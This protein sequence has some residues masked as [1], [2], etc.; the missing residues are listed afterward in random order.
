MVLGGNDA[1]TGNAGYGSDDELQRRDW[2]RSRSTP[3]ERSLG[4][5]K[6]GMLK[7]NDCLHLYHMCVEASCLCS[8]IRCTWPVL[9]IYT[10]AAT[11]L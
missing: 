11:G 10:V 6:V 1:A 9:Y 3:T 4:C 8:A 7:V 5:I 2:V